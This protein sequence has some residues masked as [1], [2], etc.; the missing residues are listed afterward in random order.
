MNHPASFTQP[1]SITVSLDS[2][3]GSADQA[4]VHSLS[5]GLDTDVDCPICFS[6]YCVVRLPKVLACQHVFC[7]VCLKL[8]LQRKEGVWRIDCPVCRKATIV[9]GGLVCSLQ[10]KEEAIGPLANVAGAFWPDAPLA[11]NP[12]HID[13]QDDGNKGVAARRLLFLLLL[14]TILAMVALPFLYPGLLKWVLCFGI[15]L[16]L[17]VAAVLCFNPNWSYNH[18]GVSLPT[19]GETEINIVT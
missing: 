9:F 16:G 17:I 1:F 7:A 3:N 14:L 10:D 8:I 6:K 2:P 12:L 13:Q 4:D 15:V 18:A 5:E 19:G 11:H